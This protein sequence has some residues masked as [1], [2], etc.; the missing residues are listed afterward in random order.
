MI[1]GRHKVRTVE[2]DNTEALFCGG[3]GR[4]SEEASVMEVE[5]RAKASCLHKLTTV[6]TGGLIC[7]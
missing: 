1:R 3:P 4:S 5:R 2:A 7:D 6:F